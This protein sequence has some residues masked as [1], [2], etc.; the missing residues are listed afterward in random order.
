M[1]AAA[2]AWK[3]GMRWR[4]LGVVARY[5]GRAA[6]IMPASTEF[7]LEKNW[8]KPRKSWDPYAFLFIKS[9]PLSLKFSDNV[10]FFV[11]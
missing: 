1:A 11:L 2:Y 8:P 6:T 9:F 3:E 7:S 4:V 10:N 5:A